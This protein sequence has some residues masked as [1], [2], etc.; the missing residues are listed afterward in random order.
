MPDIQ[1]ACRQRML[2]ISNTGCVFDKLNKIEAFQRDLHA[3]A[4]DV[5]DRA[6]SRAMGATLPAVLAGVGAMGGAIA[7]APIWPIAAAA[8]AGIVCVGGYFSI[9]HIPGSVMRRDLQ[10]QKNRI[11]TV[12]MHQAK[13]TQMKDDLFANHIHELAADKRIRDM[14]KNRPD[15]KARFAEALIDHAQTKKK[16]EIKVYR[17]PKP[18][19]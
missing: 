17:L 19:R 2:D 13:L 15:L 4:E 10:R 14:V 7:L 9:R 18:K 3:L 16:A 5:E 6:R 8:G 12:H 1:A 11:D